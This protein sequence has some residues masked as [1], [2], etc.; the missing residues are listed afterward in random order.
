[1][2]Q[3]GH[4]H[5]PSTIGL[6]HSRRTYIVQMRTLAARLHLP[7]AAAELMD[8][9]FVAMVVNVEQPYI[10]MLSFAGAIAI[11]QGRQHCQRAMHSSADIAHPYQGNVW[12]TTRLTYHR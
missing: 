11:P 12:G 7:V 2:M 8:T 1:M 6:E 5:H 3:E 10:Q 4:N 9:H